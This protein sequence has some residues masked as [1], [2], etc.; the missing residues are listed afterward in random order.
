MTLLAVVAEGA[1]RTGPK[2]VRYVTGEPSIRLLLKLFVAAPTIVP[3]GFGVGRLD[4]DQGQVIEG[5]PDHDPAELPN[6]DTAL[7]ELMTRPERGA[8]HIEQR[9]IEIEEGGG[10]G[11]HSR[12]LGRREAGRKPPSGGGGRDKAKCRNKP[13]PRYRKVESS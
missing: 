2:M 7:P 5:V 6:R 8:V 13:P 4:V 11:V 12:R 9:A 10:S 3:E 1:L